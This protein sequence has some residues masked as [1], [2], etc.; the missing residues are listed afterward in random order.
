M[1]AILRGMMILKLISLI[2]L[3]QKTI[4]LLS[5]IPIQLM[6]TPVP[7]ETLFLFLM[8][9][10]SWTFNQ[11]T[12]GYLSLPNGQVIKSTHT[13]TL[14]LPSLPL[15]A[16]AAH[17]FPELTGSLLSIGMLTDAGLTAIY[18]ADSVTI[19]DSAGVKVLSGTR[20][21]STMIDLPANPM[22]VPQAAVP[23]FHAAAVIH[24]E[25]DSQLIHYYHATLGSP[26]I[27]TFVE[28]TA[29][30]YLDCLPH[31]T[32]RKIRRNKPH[33]VATPLGHLEQTRKKYKSTRPTFAAVPPLRPT[34]Q[35]DDDLDTF[36]LHEPVSTNFIYTK[37]ERTHQNFMYCTGRFPVKS[38]AGSEYNL[39]MYSHDANYIHVEPMKRGTGR[40]VDAY[41]RGHA[42]FI[43]P[44]P[45][46]FKNHFISTLCTVDKD[47]RYNYGMQSYRKPR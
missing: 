44:R 12:R 24:H 13:A 1:L 35:I 23:Q 38:R 25:N 21:P 32:V 37:E 5:S 28:A 19:Q 20:S 6:S 45:R 18:T 36:P 40:L 8:P 4:F 34:P 30:G 17:V 14:N 7:P 9:P 26:A 31:L 46:T 41:R 15:A 47:F 27:P 22:S 39:I 3:L 33:T 16:R 2:K 11:L 29:R 42:F 43:P 10:S